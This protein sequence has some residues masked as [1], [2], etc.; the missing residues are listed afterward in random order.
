METASP[1]LACRSLSPD[2]MVSSLVEIVVGENS[3]AADGATG[4][5]AIALGVGTMLR[6]IHRYR[7]P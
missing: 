4:P 6:A 1:S 7:Y 5:L 2:S 3:G